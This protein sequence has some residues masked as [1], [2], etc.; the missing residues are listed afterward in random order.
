MTCFVS[1]TGQIRL[2]EN[3]EWLA[4]LCIVLGNDQPVLKDPDQEPYVVKETHPE[5]EALAWW[6]MT[7]PCPYC[8]CVGHE[9]MIDC[10]HEPTMKSAALYHGGMMDVWKGR[11][12]LPIHKYL[13]K[14]D[15]EVD[16]MCGAEIL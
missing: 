7:V 12:I 3:D 2:I 4:V 11:I 8:H 6:T 14:T 10:T 13:C 5:M 16:I 9:E 1:L 15:M